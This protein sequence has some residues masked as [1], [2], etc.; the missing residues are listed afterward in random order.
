LLL[1][2]SRIDSPAK[3]SIEGGI[4]V[5]Q[6]RAFRAS[7]AGVAAGLIAASAVPALAQS[8]SGQLEP[9]AGNWRTWAI[10]SGSAI[11]VPPPPD[12]D[13][14]AGEIRELK[15]HAAPDANTLE[16]MAYWDRGWPGYRWQEIFLAEAEKDSKPSIVR[17]L[18][19]VSI[20]IHDATVAAWHAKYQYAR[21]R[22]SEADSAIRALVPVPHSPSYPSEHAAVATAAADVLAY[23]FSSDAARLQQLAS[24]AGQSRIASG[25]QYPSD[26][27]AGEALGHEV[28][29]AV[30][31]HGKADRSD[32]PWDGKIR[33]G[34][35]LWAGTNPAF[36]SMGT[37]TPWVLQ[38]ADQFRPPPPPGPRSPQMAADIAE[39]KNFSR[40]P[41]ST[42]LSWFWATIPET[43][44]WV[45]ITNLK[46]FETRLSEN[47]PRAARAMAL[48]GVATYD[49]F[50]SCFE[51]KYHYLAPRPFQVDRSIIALFPAP[52]HPSYPAAHG[53]GDGAAEAVL[54]YLF[55]YDS[56][57]FKARAEEGAMSRLWAGIHFHSDIDAGLALGRSVGQLVA[58]QA[59]RDDH[60][61]PDK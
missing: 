24:E 55:P 50:V 32:T 41:V 12:A 11:A 21:Q 46:L 18:A 8:V 59:M 6:S 17:S 61:T 48:V 25:V 43:R 31:A 56:A 44:E 53:C 42:R 28:A 52:N 23:I 47:P 37:W 39:I 26:V 2:S 20:A 54:S 1:L 49:S 5:G 57:F 3:K 58:Q 13:T 7:F 36:I 27:K 60:N 4:V 35:D 9:D 29:A 22:P 38:S 40:T 45:A 19:L 30:I 14:T 16:R 33:T 34:P 15:A 10:G 51:A